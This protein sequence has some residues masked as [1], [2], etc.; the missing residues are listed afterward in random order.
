MQARQFSINLGGVLI[1]TSVVGI[2]IYLCWALLNQ[3]MPI[4]NKDALMMII[5][6][7]L[8]KFSDI[9]AWFFGGSAENKKQSE[10]IDKLAD[11][12]KTTAQTAQ[13]AIP[14][15]HPDVTLQPGQTATVEAVPDDTQS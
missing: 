1:V 15:A 7:V 9:V 13:A 8:A 2:L 11:T 5:G 3:E 10:T 14:N 12:A 6:V 4:T